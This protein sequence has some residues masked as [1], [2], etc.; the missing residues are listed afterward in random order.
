MAGI[1]FRLKKALEADT[2]TGVLKGYLFGSV[3]SSG[4]WI[5][6]IV[7]LA[8]IQLF[9]S[10][11]LTIEEADIFTTII[12][13]TFAF[14]LLFFGCMDMVITRYLADKLFLKESIVIFTSFL[15]IWGVV[16]F[17]QTAVGVILYSF[18]D[19]PLSFRF[20]SLILYIAMS[21]IW[22]VMIFLSATKNYVFI[23][24][25]FLVGAIISSLCAIEFSRN[26]GISGAMA[27][28]AL[29][30][31]TILA[32]LIW[33]I[34]K[35][36]GFYPFFSNE[37]FSYYQ[38][39]SSLMWIG[40]LYNGA[41]WGDKI[42]FWFLGPS[43]RLSGIFYNDELYGAALYLSYL[44]MIPALTIFLVKI[45]T[46]FYIAFRA[47]YQAVQNKKGFQELLAIKEELVGSL[48][49]SAQPL[50]VFQSGLSFC[51]IVFAPHI[52]NFFKL[53]QELL[54]IFQLGILGVFLQVMVVMM[55][56]IILYF[57]GIKKAIIL[58]FVFF[59]TNVVLTLITLK[60]GFPFYGYG[61]LISSLISFCLAYILLNKQ[62]EDFD[63]ET[64]MYQPIVSPNIYKIQ[65][66]EP[67][68]RAQL[69][70]NS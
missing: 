55:G 57:N 11:F 15:S 44:T 31:F 14:S 42:L 56:I 9:A 59:S 35:E 45:E 69:R 25:A 3:I 36:F 46:S 32:L 60:L 33:R 20:A 51:C 21:S 41:L 68:E 7:C 30:Q 48:R 47:Y 17:F 8:V 16:L 70:E 1:G 23:A 53:R 37:I 58:N 29:G 63:Y 10:R 2:Y 6:T 27:G 19:F 24:Q 65:A 50:I 40:F 18:C 66:L 52:L 28:M 39:F 61:F 64:F 26:Y 38:K 49:K 22:L 5:F 62:I 54:A 43:L 4:P 12:T 67:L 34:Y 13:Y